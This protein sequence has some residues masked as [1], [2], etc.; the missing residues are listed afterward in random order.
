MDS[1]GP[2][3]YGHS[4]DGLPSVMRLNGRTVTIVFAG[5]R[6]IHRYDGKAEQSSA[7]DEGLSFWYVISKFRLVNFL[8]DKG[9]ESGRISSGRA[10]SGTWPPET[11]MFTQ[12]VLVFL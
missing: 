5:Q 11:G 6:S 1:F 2:G 12:R 3:Q 7:D 10:S 4:L 8:D 9:P